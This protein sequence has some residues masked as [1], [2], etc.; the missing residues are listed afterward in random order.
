M[1]LVKCPECGKEISEHAV[2]CPSCGYPMAGGREA[3]IG[4]HA[5]RTDAGGGKPSPAA[6]FKDAG[7]RKDE[8][9]SEAEKTKYDKLPLLIAGAVVVL[10][11][12]IMS[13]VHFLAAPRYTGLP[14]QVASQ[15]GYVSSFSDGPKVTVAVHI[16]GVSEGEETVMMWDP[17]QT[18]IVGFAHLSQPAEQRYWGDVE[19]TGNVS[20][21]DGDDELDLSNASIA[22]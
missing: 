15:V 16:D 5:T 21:C 8:E 10:A 11:V 3:P 4:A 20:S 2:A 9:I 7:I 6:R 12:A 17:D 13:G 22:N 18:Y 19:I 14:A 1:A